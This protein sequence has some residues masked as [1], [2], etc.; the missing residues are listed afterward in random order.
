M[1]NTWLKALSGRLVGSIS[2]AGGSC[3][4]W[5][6]WKDR[7]A[8]LLIT[9]QPFSQPLITGI[10]GSLPPVT[11][12]LSP[13]SL[14]LWSACLLSPAS[15]QYLVCLA[16][17]SLPPSC[18]SSSPRSGH[19]PLPFFLCSEWGPPN[20]ESPSLEWPKCGLHSGIHQ[21]GLLSITYSTHFRHWS[22]APTFIPSLL[23]SLSATPPGVT[24]LVVGSKDSGA[25]TLKSK[26]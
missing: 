7:G 17:F 19:R 22:H 13:Y 23:C 16:A 5:D 14:A 20:P 11:S 4:L 12:L 26:S 2:G 8:S 3:R 24:Y 18:G 15:V 9:S 6:S 1:T 25:R 21:T 10:F